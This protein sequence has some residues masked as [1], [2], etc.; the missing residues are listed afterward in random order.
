MG[1]TG[2]REC[3]SRLVAAWLF[4]L[5]GLAARAG[6]RVWLAWEPSAS[7]GI[8]NYTV[9]WGTNHASYA[10]LTNAGLCRTQAV[11]LG[12][13]GRWYFAA[14]CQDTNGVE[15]EFSNEVVWE[16]RPLAP[17]MVGETW[18]RLAPVFGVSSNLVEWHSVTGAATW[19]QATN[20]AEY[21]QAR[22]LTLERVRAP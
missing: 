17:V 15:S 13:R 2:R 21:Y 11:T 10:Y 3:M 9:Y 4:I 12:Q 8:S 5:C 22:G 1:L 14:T 19:V 16:S 6:E 7:A 18:V 20:R